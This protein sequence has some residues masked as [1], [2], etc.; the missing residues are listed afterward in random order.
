MAHNQDMLKRR[1]E[2]FKEK[3]IRI[4]G[5]SIDKDAATVLNHCT[6]KEWMGPE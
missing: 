5:L 4:I 3:K 1:G 2:E 6:T